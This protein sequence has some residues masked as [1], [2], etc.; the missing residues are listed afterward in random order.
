MIQSDQK[1]NTGSHQLD[2]IILAAGQGRRM[3]GLRKQFEMLDNKP[4]YQH[5]I[6]QFRAH[7]ATAHIIIVVPDDEA[8]HHADHYDDE[9][10]HFVTGGVERHHSVKKGL[11]A[12][13]TLPIQAPYIAIHD[14]ARPFVP[15]HIID[16]ALIQLS[17]GHQAVIPALPVADTIKTIRADK[18]DRVAQTL[19]RSS[20]IR[21]QTPQIFTA[22]VIH[23]LHDTL[24]DTNTAYLDDACL[25]EAQNI[26]VVHITGDAACEKITWIE[27]LEKARG[28]NMTQ[29]AYRTATGFDVHRF[30]S[31]AG[32]IMICGIAVPHD[33]A[34]DAHSDGDVG[35]HALTDALLGTICDGD[36]GS[37]FPPSDE[38]WRD[39]SSDQ[40]VRHAVALIT[41]KGAAITHVDI[42][43]LCER[44][45]IGP[46]RDA[47]RSMIADL[48]NLQITAVSVKATTTEQLG[49]TGRGEGIAAQA[50]ATISYPEGAL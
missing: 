36:I 38:K 33:K 25:A 20:L 19:D 1:S 27:D 43:L 42:T 17:A 24:D 3:G 11:D 48:C 46:H 18:P 10:I 40:F 28:Q 35:L 9:M 14:A 12:L 32:P 41:D 4:L 44:P 50:A 7:H 13:R 29:K 5:A 26:E 34:L 23:H 21:V 2:V 16:N 39:A 45:K 8:L 6:D 47:M 31:G 37:H 30:T 15:S 49:F 22:D